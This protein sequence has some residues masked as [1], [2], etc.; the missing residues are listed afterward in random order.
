MLDQSLLGSFCFLGEGHS[1]S[2][3]RLVTLGV[4]Q[5]SVVT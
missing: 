4:H 1:G 3:Q 2:F 5:N